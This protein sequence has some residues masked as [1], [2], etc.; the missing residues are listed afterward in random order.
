MAKAWLERFVVSLPLL[1]WC[2]EVIQQRATAISSNLA[3]IVRRSR[4]E[5]CNRDQQQ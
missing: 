1:R 2:V 4:H 5:A 3:G